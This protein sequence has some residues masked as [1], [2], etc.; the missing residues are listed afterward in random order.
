[1]R[2]FTKDWLQHTVY[3]KGGGGTPEL[4]APAPPPPSQTQVEVTQAKLDQRRQAK[5]R[6][7]IQASI[8]AG[9]GNPL[10]Q[11]LP[12]KNSLLGGG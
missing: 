5:S 9:A 7:G 12:G 2:P 6:S 10:G 1:M 3:Y 11:G 4:P 8:M